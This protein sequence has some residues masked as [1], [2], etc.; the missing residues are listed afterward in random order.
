M[1][2][3]NPIKLKSFNIGH[4]VIILPFVASYFRCATHV[5]FFFFRY[6][7]VLYGYEDYRDVGFEA[8]SR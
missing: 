6:Y 8:E 1:Y 2:F 5:I 4:G 7:I 3:R